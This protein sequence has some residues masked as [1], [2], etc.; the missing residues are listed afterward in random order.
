MP[1][2]SLAVPTELALHVGH[3]AKIPLTGAGSVG[4]VWRV[5]VDGD[6]VLAKIGPADAQRP[7]GP[8]V[9]SLPQALIIEGRSIGHATIMLRLVR[10][11]GRP[12]R[13]QHEI[14]VIVSP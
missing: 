2:S 13:E 14:A 5:S 6:A 4:Y 12:P 10:E 8:A 3:T 11:P 9:G 7:A 1:E